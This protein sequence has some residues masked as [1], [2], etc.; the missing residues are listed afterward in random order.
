MTG[1]KPLKVVVCK[2]K[3]GFSAH[4][5]EVEGYVIARAS[6]AKL[7]K[8]LPEGIRFHIEGLYDEERQLWM[9]G[10]YGFEYVFHDVPAIPVSFNYV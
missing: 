9:N 8:D 2:A 7:K 3:N 10:E 1:M 6:V 4:L 5:P